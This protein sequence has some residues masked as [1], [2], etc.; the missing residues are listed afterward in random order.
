MKYLNKILILLI[1]VLAISL[2]QSSALEQSEFQKISPIQY[3]IKPYIQK[4]LL[5]VE[6]NQNYGVYDNTNKGFVN[7]EEKIYSEQYHQPIT[8]ISNYVTGSNLYDIYDNNTSTYIDLPATKNS[9][10]TRL[11]IE[12]KFSRNIKGLYIDLAQGNDKVDS[13][14]LKNN[15]SK[16]IIYTGQSTNLSFAEIRARPLELIITHSQNIRINE[17]KLEEANPEPKGLVVTFLAFPEVK[18]T[19]YSKTENYSERYNN[20]SLNTD[21]VEVVGQLSNTADNN[22]YLD[23][24][25][26]GD[27]VIDMKDNCP[28]VSNKDQK[29]I[30]NNKRGDACE[31]NDGDGIKDGVDNCPFVANSAQV[32]IDGDKKGDACDKVDDRYLAQN[33]W[34]LWT[35][36]GLS[37]VG[38]L[39]GTFLLV[40]PKNIK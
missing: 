9:T 8:N 14:I 32:D 29:D 6:L 13:I 12:N 11:L 15:D 25:A 34:I 5:N 30:N 20:S 22:L 7:T 2:T 31:D 10:E 1:T 27:G 21:A 40:K 24:D 18:Y 28:S 35:G 17:I 36:I 4:I 3:P 26:D 39:A 16:S 19:L 37:M 38:F 33:R 23:S